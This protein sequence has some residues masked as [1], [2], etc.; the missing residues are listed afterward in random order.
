MITSLQAEYVLEPAAEQ[1]AG[2]AGND[3]LLI[4]RLQKRDAAAFDLLF[5]RYQPMVRRIAFQF[6]G[7]R[8]D[9]ADVT[10]EVFLRIYQN[11]EHFKGSSSL[12]T[13]IYRIVVNSALNRRRWWKRRRQDLQ[14]SWHEGAES[15][16]PERGFRNSSEDCLPNPE[17]TACR[18][19]LA[20]RLQDAFA[21]LPFDQRMAVILRDLEGMGYEEMASV[22]CLSTGTVKSRIA[23]GR[24]ALRKELESYLQ[25]GRIS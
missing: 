11:I 16:I 8:E 14:N 9:T 12:K 2:L 25:T 21:R 4:Q 1:E 17:Q 19:E 10:Q 5:H 13:W 20:R 18:R 6:L 23:R 22:L 3:C 7:N 24:E 15:E